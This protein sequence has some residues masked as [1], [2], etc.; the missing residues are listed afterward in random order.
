MV[1][2]ALLNRQRDNKKLEEEGLS[3]TQISTVRDILE[4]YLAPTVD[5]RNRCESCA[6]CVTCTPLDAMSKKDKLDISKLRENPEI[7]SNITFVNDPTSVGKLRVVTK[8]PSLPKNGLAKN[9]YNSVVSE[10]D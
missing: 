10:M 1:T 9:N 5:P 6:K 2:K 4:K 3:K 7:F 8:L